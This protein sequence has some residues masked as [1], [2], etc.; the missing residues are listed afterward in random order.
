MKKLT[1]KELKEMTV[2]DRIGKEIPMTIEQKR[3]FLRFFDAMW[4][5]FDKGNNNE[6]I[7]Q[8]RNS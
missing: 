3:N 2:T 4:V 1:E 6:E 7:N 5:D 8:K